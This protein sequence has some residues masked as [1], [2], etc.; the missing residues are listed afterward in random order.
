M[1]TT[2]GKGIAA[3]MECDKDTGKQGEGRQDETRR[4]KPVQCCEVGRAGIRMRVQNG[5][6][7]KVAMTTEAQQHRL[8]RQRRHHLCLR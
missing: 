7:V 2:K 4:D 5:V 3:G 8:V 6:T 1:L